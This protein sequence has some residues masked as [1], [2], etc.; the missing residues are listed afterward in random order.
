M[1]VIYLQYL[2][3]L[4]HYDLLF[5]VERNQTPKRI[6]AQNIHRMRGSRNLL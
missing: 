4:Q 5:P 2:L 1:P 6:G 3:L